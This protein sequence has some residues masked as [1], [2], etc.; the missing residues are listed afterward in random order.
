[1]PLAAPVALT[2][3]GAAPAYATPAASDSVT[4]PV[5]AQRLIVHVKN[6]NAADCTVTVTSQAPV[7]DGVAKADRVV[8]VPLGTG[9]RIFTLSSAFRAANGTVSFAFSVTSSV[10][11]AVW[12]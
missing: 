8:V 4:W 12:H 10:T 7:S 6:A 11:A 3:A 1:M 5:N 2:P 9:E